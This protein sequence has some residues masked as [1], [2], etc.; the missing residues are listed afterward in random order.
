MDKDNAKLVEVNG[1]EFYIDIEPST[2]SD[3]THYSVYNKENMNIFFS[4]VVI[5]DY[6]E[7]DILDIITIGI[8]ES[9]EY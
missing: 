6:N 3:I 2:R 9:L 7:N 1:M 5:G 4:D 8:K